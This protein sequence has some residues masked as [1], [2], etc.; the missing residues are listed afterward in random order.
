M[1]IFRF[2]ISRTDKV[3]KDKTDIVKELRQLDKK[4][5]LSGM[6]TDHPVEKL[7]EDKLGRGIFAKE[8]A[9]GLLNSFDTSH[10]S[11]VVGINGPWGSGKTSLVNMIIEQVNSLAEKQG[12]KI[13]VLRFNPWMFSGQ[14]ELQEIF[15][16]ELFLKLHRV[17][18]KIGEAAEKLAKFADYLRWLKYMHSGVGELVKDSKELFET[19]SEKKDLSDL[20]KELDDALIESDIRLYITIDDIDRLTPDEISHIFQLVKL[21]ANFA[22]T[23]FILVYDQGVVWKALESQFKENGRKYLEKIIQVDYELPR[24]AKKK[25]ANVFQQSITSLFPD[26]KIV[27]AIEK[28]IPSLESEDFVNSFGSLRDIYRFCNGIKLRLRSIYGEL[29]IRDFFITETLRI[30]HHDAYEFVIESKM[31]LTQKDETDRVF[32]LDLDRTK[33][34]PSQFIDASKFDDQSKVLLRRLFVLEGLLDTRSPE[35]LVAERRVANRNYFDRYFYL[36]LSD[37]DIPEDL[38]DNF[39]ESTDLDSRLE[40][41]NKIKSMERLYHYFTWMEIKLKYQNRLSDVAPVL[42]AALMFSNSIH[43]FSP[44]RFMSSDLLTIH[45]F[46]SKMLYYMQ[47]I[48]DRRELIINYITTLSEPNFASVQL[49]RDILRAREMFDQ[50]KLGS[51]HIWSDLFDEEFKPA[52]LETLLGQHLDEGTKS[53]FIKAVSGDRF[54]NDDELSIVLDQAYKLHSATYDAEFPKLIEKYD[55]LL[56]ILLMCIISRS[57]NYSGRPRL[58]SLTRSQLYEKMDLQNIQQRLA[59]L[60][61]TQLTQEQLMTVTF[62]QRAFEDGFSDKRYYSFEDPSNFVDVP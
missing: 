6:F 49:S 41:L 39:I 21:N 15:L 27:E 11:V 29:D 48:E 32:H 22:N 52:K 58:F 57:V 38:F 60:D 19:L 53:L 47:D 25:L 1:K 45:R 31:K 42:R 35:S 55:G 16:K 17:K 23:F 12:H 8:I 36:Q 18:G 43:W 56:R 37:Q 3:V 51:D 50:G 14:R 4:G 5:D 40:I 62:F 10:E 34:T 46:C 20:K 26:K 24:I 28:A 9:D 2:T 13:L 7:S 30:F 44:Y 61:K 33:T 54:L 59:G